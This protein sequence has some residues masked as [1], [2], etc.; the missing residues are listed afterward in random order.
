[1]KTYDCIIIGGGIIGL[2]SAW[3][4]A[5]RGQKVLVVDRGY[6]GRE[7]SWAAAGMLPPIDVD[8]P[9]P[10]FQ[11]LFRYS[12][13]CWRTLA[14]QL[15]AESG[16]DPGYRACGS[17]ILF[18]DAQQRHDAEAFWR[19]HGIEPEAISESDSRGWI[20]FHIDAHRQVWPRQHLLA[21]AQGCLRHG[22]DLV[23]QTE[24]EGVRWAISGSQRKVTSLVTSRGDYLSKLVLIAAGCWTGRLAKLFDVSLPTKPIRGQ[25]VLLKPHVFENFGIIEKGHRY[26]VSRIDETVL[27]GSTM[28]DVGFDPRVTEE[29]TSELLDFARMSLPALGDAEVIDRWSGLRPATPDGLP[30]LGQVRG[31]ENLW[32]SSGHFRNG[33]LLSMGSACLIAQ[34]IL[35]EPLDVNLEPFSPERTMASSLKDQSS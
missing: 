9:T 30:W 32:V 35:G 7:A 31:Y 22:V 25:I 17:T 34:A 19:G 6:L 3:E 15:F 28:E 14:G 24:V 18:E 11:H 12:F 27:V 8:A 13:E 33:I 4:L 29:G 1:M 26:L 21:L 20:G 2:T 5:R 23:E 10:E 16:V